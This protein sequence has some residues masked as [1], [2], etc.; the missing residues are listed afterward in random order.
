MALVS[1]VAA[2]L[3]AACGASA[4]AGSATGGGNGR[5]VGQGQ[6]P[7]GGQPVDLRLSSAVRH[8]RLV[9]QDGQ[10]FTL[11]SLRGQTV[12]VAP[13]LTL[14]EETCPM[15][16]ENMHLAA[17][18]EQ[19]SATAGR[20]TFVEP[21]VDPRRDTVHRLHAYAK[22]YGALPDWS[23]ATGSAA[24]MTTWWRSLGV[25]TQKVPIHQPVR[26][27]MTGRLL[28]NPYDVHHE[29]VAMVID[30]R[31]HV[32]WIS[33]GRP[34][35]RGQQLPT[36]LSGFLS[37]EGRSNYAHPGAQGASTWTAND[38]E[39]AVQYVEGGG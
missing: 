10:H 1:P 24:T 20:V 38:V 26:D 18:Y 27:W 4:G 11:A 36:R 25:S 17:S 2:L 28:K 39:Q 5:V 7:G 12:V 14:C 33:L 37:S 30:P 23:L 35:A 29:D 9:D 32:R 15:T 6:A 21:T 16:S 13:L 8:L 22:L 3:L 34:D 19:S 31:G